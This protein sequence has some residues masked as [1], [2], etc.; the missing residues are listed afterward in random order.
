VRT[1]RIIL[2]ALTTS[3]AVAGLSGLLLTSQLSTG[4]PP[5]GPGYLRR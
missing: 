5:V 2:F 4:D 1:S 3:G